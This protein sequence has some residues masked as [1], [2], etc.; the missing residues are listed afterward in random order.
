[1]ERLDARPVLVVLRRWFCAVVW[2]WWFYLVVLALV[3]LVLVVPRAG[4][5]C[6]LCSL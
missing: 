2:R 6:L 1:M 5:S 3:V 4:V